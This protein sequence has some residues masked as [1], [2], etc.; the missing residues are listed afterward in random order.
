L[1][2][3]HGA[4]KNE[5]SSTFKALGDSR[6]DHANLP[7]QLLASNKAPDVLA[8]QFC[9]VAPY[10]YPQRSF[11]NE[12][13]DKLLQFIQ[14]LPK[15]NV[16][17]D[18]TRLFLFGF[19]DGATVAVEL[20]T[21]RLFCGIVVA[22]YGYTGAN[23]PPFALQ[24][25]KGIGMWVWHSVDDAV[26]DVGNSDRLVRALQATNG[27]ENTAL[28]DDE[29]ALIRYTRYNRD[30]LPGKDPSMRGH[31]SMGFMA[32]QTSE[33]YK[34]MLTLPCGS[35]SRE[36]YSMARRSDPSHM[37][38]MC[39]LNLA[40]DTVLDNLTQSRSFIVPFTYSQYSLF[41]KSYHNS[42]PSANISWLGT[43]KAIDF[44]NKFYQSLMDISRWVC[45]ILLDARAILTN[46]GFL[47]RIQRDFLC[48]AKAGT[49][50]HLVY[51][52]TRGVK[53]R[54]RRPSFQLTRLGNDY[55]IRLCPSPLIGGPRW[56]LLHVK[57]ILRT[58][59]GDYTW[60]FVPKNATD[61]KVLMGL[62]TLQSVPGTIRYTAPVGPVSAT[63][64]TE[65]MV[66]L[67][68]L[69]CNNYPQELNLVTNNCWTFAIQLGLYL[70]EMYK[71][72]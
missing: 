2:V 13:R 44:S 35:K 68:Q 19:S 71:K 4:G 29:G 65:I 46:S 49:P 45:P 62:T 8:E 69:Y 58:K 5:D 30:P 16:H 25:L 6:G 61:Q 21:S 34:W 20:A 18:P 59:K 38:S 3:L 56:L 12:P 42:L 28:G 43:G 53:D 26:F 50:R 23:L 22:A 54:W 40:R 66:R 31:V 32:S 15:Y 48:T 64:P 7:L 14:Q 11:L 51:A 60:D 63:G 55:E 27:V 9:V 17:F 52:F 67:A 10:A 36:P 47:S 1:V 72:A 24:R 33:V 37:H 39:S 57:L 70:T 41:G